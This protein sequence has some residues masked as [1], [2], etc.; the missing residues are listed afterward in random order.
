MHYCIPTHIIVSVN[1]LKKNET[2]KNNSIQGIRNY[3]FIG[4]K[5]LILVPNV[6]HNYN[7]KFRFKKIFKILN[8]CE[9]MTKLNFVFLY[10]NKYH[11]N[12]FKNM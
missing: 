5:L 3:C 7:S 8:M 12:N 11:T 10:C 9:E 2:N 6:D 1:N 4:R